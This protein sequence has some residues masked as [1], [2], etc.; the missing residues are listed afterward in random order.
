MLHRLVARDTHW[1]MNRRL[2]R[3]T[4]QDATLRRCA[5]RFSTMAAHSVSHLLMC[6]RKRTVGRFFVELC[7][8]GLGLE[9]DRPTPSS[10]RQG[11]AVSNPGRARRRTRQPLD[12]MERSETVRTPGRRPR[13]QAAAETGPPPVHQ[14]TPPH[15]APPPRP[16]TDE[17]GTRATI[18]IVRTWYPHWGQYSG[19]N[20]F[21][22]SW[23]PTDTE[24]RHN[25]SRRTTQSFRCRTASYESGFAIGSAEKTWRGTT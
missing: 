4:R 12:L 21:L 2:S 9:K 20:Q 1:C 25:W 17:V 8:S 7:P 14:L 19:I 5:P 13:R 23:T 6:F 15:A 24:S 16:Q 10:A 11:H 3:G 18:R 22:N